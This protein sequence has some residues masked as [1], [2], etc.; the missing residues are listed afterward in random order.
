MVMGPSAYLLFGWHQK[1]FDHHAVPRIGASV[2]GVGPIRTEGAEAVVVF[3]V[4]H[5]TVGGDDGM[6]ENK[7]MQL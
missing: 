1:L 4:T 3:T 6:K 7:G 2:Q 5:S